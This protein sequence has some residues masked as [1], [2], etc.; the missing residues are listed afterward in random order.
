[1]ERPCKA[2]YG[3]E[4]HRYA[5]ANSKGE[6][7]GHANMGRVEG[8]HAEGQRVAESVESVDLKGVIEESGKWMD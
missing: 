5:D 2:M 8:G 3:S 1:M 4:D 6:K 7:I